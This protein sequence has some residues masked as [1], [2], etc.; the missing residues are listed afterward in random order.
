MPAAMRSRAVTHAARS[1]GGHGDAR[2]FV[3]VRALSCVSSS[4]FDQPCQTGYETA[5]SARC[6]KV[7]K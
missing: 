2:L 1:L 5:V 6:L 7:Q 4:P 3:R